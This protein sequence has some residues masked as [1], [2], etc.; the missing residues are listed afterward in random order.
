MGGGKRIGEIDHDDGYKHLCIMDESDIYQEQMKRSVQTENFKHVRSALKSKLNAGNVLKKLLISGLSQQ[1]KME[2][3]QY[4]EQ[5]NFKKLIG[6][7]KN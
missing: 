5:K 7:L 1:S 3:E 6:R 4:N 2:L